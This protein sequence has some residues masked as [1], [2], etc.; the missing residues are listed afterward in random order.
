MSNLIALQKEVCSR[1]LEVLRARNR[2]KL[3]VS[4]AT[5]IPYST[6]NRKLKGRGEFTLSELVVLADELRVHPSALLPE[7]ILVPHASHSEVA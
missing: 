7:S 3:S 6:L 2:T 5:G 4:E 1:F